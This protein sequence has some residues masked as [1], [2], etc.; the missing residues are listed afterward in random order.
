MQSP[1]PALTLVSARP[2]RRSLAIGAAALLAL[3]ITAPDAFAQANVNPPTKLTY[4]GFLTSV[5]G[6]PLG[7]TSPENKTVV[8]RIYDAAT[9]GNLKWASRQTVTFDKGYFSVLLGE[10]DADPSNATLFNEGNLT[11]VFTDGDSVANR[12]LEIVVDGTSIAPRLQF[13]TSPYAFLA[14]RAK[15]V[16]AS[17]VT[18]GVLATDRIP[19]LDTA[20]ITSGALATD[21]IPSLDAAKITTGTLSVDRIPSMNASKINAGTLDDARLSGNVAKLG[22]A[23][24]FTA[25]NTFN[26]VIRV[27][28]SKVI[29]FGY[30]VAN[31]EGSAGQIGYGTHSGGSSSATA[32]LDI[33]GAGTSGGSRRVTMWAEGGFKVNGGM[34]V[35]GDVSSSTYRAT[36]AL[37]TG[38]AGG[39]EAK[40]YR[41]ADT[42]F[43]GG[44]SLWHDQASANYH[45]ATYNGDNNW[46]FA[47]DKRLKRNIVDAEPVLD[48]LLKVRFR[49]FNW[50][51]QPEGGK[52]E[53]GVVAQELE[54]I[55]PDLVDEVKFPDQA[56]KMKTVGYTSFGTI[57]AKA[58]Q[59]LKA[60]TDKEF[61]RL[62]AE[63]EALKVE[64]KDLRTKV[65]ARAEAGEAANDLAVLRKELESL[66]A[67]VAELRP[68]RASR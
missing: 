49:R 30:D 9:G 29:N 41:D 39:E 45:W 46:D 31:R 51:T 68:L 36:S 21:R 4:Q 57:A 8:F 43:V 58:I 63:I 5:S 15:E 50:K 35:S 3:A 34:T 24:T 2:S 1:L 55:F 7:N 27:N 60:Q 54:P 12:H 19:S 40:I 56:E 64:N 47:S 14:R 42:I 22:S 13:L 38:A 18:T 26:E 6:V 66:R 65:Q 37:Y 33:V 67:T 11:G 20:K 62:H 17:A 61:S 59:E 10:G 32:S 23:Q 53:F 16:D 52:A 48:S 44:N 25:I 28:G